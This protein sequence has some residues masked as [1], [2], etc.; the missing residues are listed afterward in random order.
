MSRP[1]R[2]RRGIVILVVLAL[3]IV[4]GGVAVDA[5]AR[6]VVERRASEALMAEVSTDAPL[7][8]SI[9][10]WPFLGL[11]VTDRVDSVRIVGHDVGLPHDGRTITLASVDATAT[12]VQHPRD[13]ARAK[14]DRL[15]VTGVMTWSD[16]SREIGIEVAYGGDGRLQATQRIEI[17]GVGFD[18]VFSAVPGVDAETQRFTLTDPMA[19]VGPLTTTAG[20]L[21][22]LVDQVT[23]AIP[24]P[25]LKGVDYRSAMA[26]EAGLQVV[27]V[28]EAVSLESLR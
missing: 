28:G 27:L 6:N 25:D 24:L 15:D 8:V 5:L 12:G 2:G 26:T 11:L 21:D 13:F 19:A 7:D 10:G 22:R 16:L 4:G 18:A 3:V 20:L 14:A 17:L 1:G 23:D 9:G